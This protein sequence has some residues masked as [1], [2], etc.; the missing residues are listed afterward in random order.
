MMSRMMDMMMILMVMAVVMSAVTMNMHSDQL[1]SLGSVVTAVI[2][3]L[4]FR[5]AIMLTLVAVLTATTSLTCF[6]S[7]SVW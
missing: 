5:T 4:V 1:L 2:I 7:R 3:V 6:A